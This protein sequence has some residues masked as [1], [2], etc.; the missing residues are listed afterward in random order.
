MGIYRVDLATF[1]KVMSLYREVDDGRLIWMHDVGGVDEVP[2]VLA[3][4]VTAREL[5]SY[6]P[7]SI[8]ALAQ[9]EDYLRQ[10]LSWDDRLSTDDVERRV[11]ARKVRQR[12]LHP[13]SGVKCTFVV[14]ELTLRHL[15]GGHDAVWGQLMNLFWLANSE[16][17][18][19]RVIGCDVP[20]GYQGQYPFTLTRTPEFRPVVHVDTTPFSLFLDD[21]AESEAYEEMA[22]LLLGNAMSVGESQKLITNL[23]EQRRELVDSGN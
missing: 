22:R 14:R 4:E 23:A 10:V 7:V 9:S 15:P 17:V 6:E 20:Y 19:V 3:N 5:F 13:R 16:K 11:K 8:P 12:I 1:N 21:P 18:S 2:V